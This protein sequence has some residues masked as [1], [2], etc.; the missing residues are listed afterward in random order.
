MLFWYIF[1]SGQTIYVLN[2]A[3]PAFKS[4]HRFT[5]ILTIFIIVT[6]LVLVFSYEMWCFENIIKKRGK[7]YSKLFLALNPDLKM[8]VYKEIE[9]YPLSVLF[10]FKWNGY[11]I[12]LKLHHVSLKILYITTFIYQA[13]ISLFIWNVMKMSLKKNTI[14]KSS[15]PGL[16]MKKMDGTHCH[17]LLK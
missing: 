12:V 6:K 4:L 17:F 2:K 14:L 11:V 16:C 8:L 3:E 5:K 9:R 10:L 7:K 13:N 15:T 1:I